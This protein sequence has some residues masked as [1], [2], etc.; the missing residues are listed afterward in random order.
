MKCCKYKNCCNA[1]TDGRKSKNFCSDDCRRH[2]HT[3]LK[4]ERNRIKEEKKHIF[5]LINEYETVKK[6]RIDAETIDLFMKI[7]NK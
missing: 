4:R 6:N 2:Y 7:Y 1:I 3:Y 5:N